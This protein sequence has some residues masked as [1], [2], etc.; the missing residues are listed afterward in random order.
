M[1]ER[2]QTKTVDSFAQLKAVI[3]MSAYTK[4]SMLL[5][6]TTSEEPIAIIYLYL[7]ADWRHRSKAIRSMRKG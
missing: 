7:S 4:A 6:I 2:A 3:F 5:Y 1:K